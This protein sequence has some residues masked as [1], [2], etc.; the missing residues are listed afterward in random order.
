[1]EKIENG[2]SS[3]SVDVEACGDGFGNYLERLESRFPIRA[4]GEYASSLSC[5]PLNF[6]GAPPSPYLVSRPQ[7]LSS[8]TQEGGSV[9][10]LFYRPDESM[11]L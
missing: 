2:P 10:H 6:L 5:I 4:R 7:D 1:M 9:F 11:L 3:R 8:G